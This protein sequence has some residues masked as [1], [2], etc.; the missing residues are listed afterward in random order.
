MPV[1][2]IK[3]GEFK[4]K[5]QSDITTIFKRLDSIDDDLKILQR[6]NGWRGSVRPGLIGGGGVAILHTI[7]ELLKTAAK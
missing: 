4:G 5:T 3:Y 2:D 7:V 6:K 1:E